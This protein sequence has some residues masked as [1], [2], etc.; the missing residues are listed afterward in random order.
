MQSPFYEMHAGDKAPRGFLETR[1]RP[2]D[3]KFNTS[4][5]A[6]AA[7]T[8]ELRALAALSLTESD[9]Q[10]CHRVVVED[11][12]TSNHAATTVHERQPLAAAPHPIAGKLSPRPRT[13]VKRGQQISQQLRD[14]SR[15]VQQAAA[16]LQG[17]MQ[18]EFRRQ[19]RRFEEVFF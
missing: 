3:P 12:T 17:D 15:S 9:T 19:P 13:R 8:E 5:S 18:E 4:S 1:W 16:S 10:Q 14:M 7:T 6:S 2:R 11:N